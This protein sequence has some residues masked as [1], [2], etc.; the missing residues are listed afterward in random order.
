V[1][2]E[3][4]IGEVRVAT[5]SPDGRHII[6]AGE[7]GAFSVCPLSWK[8]KW[9]DKEASKVAPSV[10]LGKELHKSWSSVLEESLLLGKWIRYLAVLLT[11]AAVLFLL[12][13]DPEDSLSGVFFVSVRSHGLQLL[14]LIATTLLVIRSFRKA[15]RR[16]HRDS[17]FALSEIAVSIEGS[18][19]LPSREY[20]S[21]QQGLAGKPDAL[22]KEGQLFLPIERKPL[23]KKLRDRYVAQLLVYMRLVEEF[24][25]ATPP[26]G[27]LLLGPKCRRVKIENAPQKQEW[28][29]GMIREMRAILDGAPVVPQP[30]PMKCAKCDVRHRCSARVDAPR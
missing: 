18:S 12:I 26:H 16:R 22:V 1:P 19:I 25:G 7:V 17:G 2:R 21:V 4:R 5:I 15:A 8:L 20:I 27:Y 6:A 14:V 29:E 3:R 23:A 28:V 30:H 13:H 11:S 10:E 24:E 9:I